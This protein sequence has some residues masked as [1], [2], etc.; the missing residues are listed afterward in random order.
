MEGSD[1]LVRQHEVYFRTWE[2]VAMEAVP[3]E[4]QEA[5]LTSPAPPV[6]SRV[7]TTALLLV[8]PNAQSKFWEIL[9]NF[10][11][12][13][14]RMLPYLEWWTRSFSFSYCQIHFTFCFAF[15]V[16]L[17]ILSSSV[18]WV[19]GICSAIGLSPCRM[20]RHCGGVKKWPTIFSHL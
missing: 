19:I 15:S 4:T 12:M 5:V 18:T 6:A 11:L 3:Q 2:A 9:L 8:W 20:S 1:T 13:R 10:Y 7:I 14:C 16:T 17:H